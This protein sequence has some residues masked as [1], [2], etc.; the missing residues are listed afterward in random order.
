M[1]HPIPFM[2]GSSYGEVFGDGGAIS[3]WIKSKMATILKNQM[4]KSLKRIFPFTSCMYTDPTLSS[5][6]NL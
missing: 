6:S 2:F 4:A 5:D 3:V 1:S